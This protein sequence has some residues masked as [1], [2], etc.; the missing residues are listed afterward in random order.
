MLRARSTASKASAGGEVNLSHSGL[1]TSSSNWYA[2]RYLRASAFCCSAA[3]A[4]SAS[5]SRCI[6]ACARSTARRTRSAGSSGCRPRGCSPLRGA[7]RCRAP[8]WEPDPLEHGE[9]PLE[10]ADSPE[11]AETDLSSQTLCIVSTSARD[12]GENESAARMSTSTVSIAASPEG[13][14]WQ[15]LRHVSIERRREASI[16]AAWCDRSAKAYSMAVPP[17]GGA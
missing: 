2:W 9:P 8:P 14:V 11:L 16:A 3:N 1:A 15:P 13:Q 10:S 12:P 4:C 7:S 6:A 17:E 5:S